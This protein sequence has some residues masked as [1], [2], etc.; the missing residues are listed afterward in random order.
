MEPEMKPISVYADPRFTQ[1]TVS[2]LCRPH[3]IGGYVY[4]F[5]SHNYAGHNIN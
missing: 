1:P 3:N 2:G 4:L 5:N